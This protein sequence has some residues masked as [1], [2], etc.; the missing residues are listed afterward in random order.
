VSAEAVEMAK[1]AGYR[2]FHGDLRDSSYGDGFFDVVTASEI[3]EHLPE[4]LAYL[5]EIARVLRS[6][7]LFWATTPSA[8]ALSS[9][10]LRLHWSMLCPPEHIQLYSAEGVRKMLTKAGFA[11][12]EFRTYGISPFEI[13]SHFRNKKAAKSGFERVKA[14]Y[15]L[16]E[17]LT[18]SRT[19]KLA[20]TVVNGCLNKSGLGDSLKI[21]AVN[22]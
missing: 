6:G 5:D 19:G 18:R 1:Q 11:N 9:R 4:P 22:R 20:K 7:G 13:I 8:R 21:Y 16:N 10:L 3:L 2:V 15:E 17:K 12:V 14:G